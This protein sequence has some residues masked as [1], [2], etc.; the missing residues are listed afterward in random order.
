MPLEQPACDSDAYES[1]ALPGGNVV[2]LGNTGKNFGAGMSGG[3]A[4]VYDPEKRLPDFCNEDVA[5][6]LSPITDVEV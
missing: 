1:S 6:D 4:Y 2:I 3:L 5:G